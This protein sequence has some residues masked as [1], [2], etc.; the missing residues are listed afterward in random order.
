[1]RQDGVFDEFGMFIFML[2]GY[3]FELINKVLHHENILSSLPLSFIQRA[4]ESS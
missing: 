2:V 3:F 4:Q 1:M